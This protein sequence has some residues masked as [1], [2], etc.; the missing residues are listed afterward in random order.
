MTIRKLTCPITV[1]DKGQQDPLWTSLQ[2]HIKL[3]NIQEAYTGG[4]IG[5][6]KFKSKNIYL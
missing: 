2:K 5:L 4:K 1:Q 6:E 3:A